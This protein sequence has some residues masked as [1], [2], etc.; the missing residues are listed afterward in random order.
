MDMKIVAAVVLSVV[1]AACGKV[2]KEKAEPAVK[3][4]T[5]VVGSSVAN[6]EK[7]YSGTIEAGMISELS[8]SGGGT[9][10]R[11]A[12]KAGDRVSKGQLIAVVDRQMAQNEYNSALSQEQ[13]A[14]DLYERYKKMYEERSLPEAQYIEAKS[15]LRQSEM[16]LAMARKQLSD[17]QLYAPFAGTITARNGEPGQNVGAGAVVATLVDVRKMKVCISVT[18]AEINTFRRGQNVRISVPDLG[19]QQFIGT[20]TE[21]DIQADELSRTYRIKALTDNAHG[22][23]LPGMIA[24]VKISGALNPQTTDNIIIPE[25]L[26]QIM[27]DNTRFVWLV[28]DGKAK[29]QVVTIGDATSQGVIVESGLQQGDTLITEGQQK[30]SEGSRVQF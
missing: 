21:K 3:V 23:L 14:R 20:I 12:V 27:S 11:V 19:G 9:L 6:D 29:L 25:K 22:K 26:V 13:R 28:R 5:I 18:A 4:K 17:C 24:N 10:T 2:E 8:F 15:A 16:Q 1:M 30:V 7:T